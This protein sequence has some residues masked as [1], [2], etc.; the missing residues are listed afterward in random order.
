MSENINIRLFFSKL[1]RA[2]YISAL[3]LNKC[4][5]RAIRRTD[6]PVWQT[7]GFNPHTY[8][9]FALPLALG[10]EGI[11]ESMDLKLTEEVPFEQVVDKLNA[12]LPRDIRALKVAVPVNKHTAIEKAEYEIITDCD[13]ELLLDFFAQDKIITQKK[14]KKGIVDVDLKEHIEIISAENGK[15]IMRLP[16][17]VN[18]TINPSLV[19]DAFSKAKNLE[20]KR[21]SIT[22]THILCADGTDFA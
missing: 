5:Q 8:V 2:K 4:M 15:L 12:V 20:I 13:M 22:R 19:F 16:A 14:T 9:T 10:T 1:D 17:G 11:W 18:F 21:L 6:L 3:D 7:E